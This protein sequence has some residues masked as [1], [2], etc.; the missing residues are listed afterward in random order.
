M[1]FTD[2]LEQNHTL[3]FSEFDVFTKDNIT[4]RYLPN[5]SFY[6]QQHNFFSTPPFTKD[7]FEEEKEKRTIK[8]I[9]RYNEFV[10]RIIHPIRQI[11]PPATFTC[12]HILRRCKGLFLG[13]E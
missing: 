13:Q 11:W 7:R 5:H 12:S 3:P 1:K 10:N 8:K 6:T 2:K 9:A 4:F